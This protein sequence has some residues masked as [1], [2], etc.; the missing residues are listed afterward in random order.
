M[1]SVMLVTPTTRLVFAFHSYRAGRRMH[2]KCDFAYTVS[3]PER[4]MT[5]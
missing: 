1:H 3:K 2:C 5:S 4:E